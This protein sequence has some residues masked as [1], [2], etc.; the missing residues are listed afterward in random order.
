MVELINT[1]V[2]VEDTSTDPAVDVELVNFVPVAEGIDELVIAAV[3]VATVPSAD[4]MI[5]VSVPGFPPSSEL[6]EV[7][8]ELVVV[9]FVPVPPGLVDAVNAVVFKLV[10]NSPDRELDAALVL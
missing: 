8:S 3:S 7:T 5:P 4:E 10:N 6:A 9:E 1:A 2:P